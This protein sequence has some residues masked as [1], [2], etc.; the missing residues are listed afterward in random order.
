MLL[1]EYE[2]WKLITDRLKI[3]KVDRSRNKLQQIYFLIVTSPF[4]CQ[5]VILG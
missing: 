2:T 3:Y 4:M 5:S 1:N